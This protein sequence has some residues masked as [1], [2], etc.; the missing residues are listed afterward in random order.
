MEM[1]HGEGGPVT[2]GETPSRR[3]RGPARTVFR[4]SASSTQ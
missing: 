1:G 3:L 4:P 2:S